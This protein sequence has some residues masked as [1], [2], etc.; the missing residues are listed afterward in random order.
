VRCVLKCEMTVRNPPSKND[1]LLNTTMH[2]EDDIYPKTIVQF[3]VNFMYTYISHR[4]TIK[5]S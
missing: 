4:T 1:E 2:Q 3:Y 5:L